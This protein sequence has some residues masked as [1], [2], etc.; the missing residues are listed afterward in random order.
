MAKQLWK[1]GTVL[2]PLPAVMISCGNIDG[3]SNIFTAAWTGI[4]NSE[5]PMT[6]VSIR[7]SRH[8][9]NIIKQ[10][11]EF[12]INTTTESLAEQTDFCGVRSG[13][14]VDKFKEM[15][16]T[17]QKAAYVKCPLIAESPL[18][19][20]C[21]V[22]QIIPLGSHDMFMAEILG[23]MADEKYM[24][25]NGKFDFAGSKPICYSH[26]EYFGLGKYLGK[27]G[28]SVAKSKEKKKRK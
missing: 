6:Y 14:D 24:C 20:E 10:S 5:P 22:T 19:I 3:E 2:Y 17:R 21:R 15:K 12:V 28:Y 4:I 18:S 13:R 27:F 1:A 9:Y 16:L 23:V 8:S 25:E 7:P 26:G 11:G